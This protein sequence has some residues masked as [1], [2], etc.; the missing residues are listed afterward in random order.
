M[1]TK[2]DLYKSN[3]CLYKFAKPSISMKT[4]TASFPIGTFFMQ[5]Q[6]QKAV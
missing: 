4:K 3:L 5:T 1:E 6:Q 2:T